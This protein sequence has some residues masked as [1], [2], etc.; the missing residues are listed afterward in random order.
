[1]VLTNANLTSRPP[2]RDVIPNTLQYH[3]IITQGYL[4]LKTLSYQFNCE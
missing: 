1:M 2:G 3:S 4:V